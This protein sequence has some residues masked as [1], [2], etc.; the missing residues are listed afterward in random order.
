MPWAIAFL[1]GGDALVT[2]RESARLLRVTPRGQV[3]EAGVIEGVSASGEGGLLGVAVSPR[4]AA[5]HFV[6]VYFTAQNDNRIV[7]YRY[8][9]R[10]SDRRVIVSGIPKGAIHNGGRLAF[11]PDGYLYASTGETGERGMAQE[12]SSLGG[13]ILRMTVDGRPAPGNPFG[14]LVWTYGHRNVQGLAW[15]GRGHMYATE[16]GQNTYDE[17]NLIEKGHNYGWPEVE[18]VSGRPG[19]T[20]PLLTW[21]TAE[22]SPSGLA[23]ARGRCGPGRCAASASGACRWTLR[24]AS[25]VL[26]RS[27]RASTAGCARWPPRPAARCG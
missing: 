21:S 1:P 26:P 4:Y 23:Y 25:A 18:G 11:G 12:R 3:H 5:D 24:A 17:I 16:F 9:G 2:E 7:R 27:T 15:D 13:K 20:D 8:D 6:F 14:T 22:A 10:L 19:Y